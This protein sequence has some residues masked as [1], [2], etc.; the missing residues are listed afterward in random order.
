[1]QRDRLLYPCYFDRALRRSEG[2]RVHRTMAVEHPAL[3]DIEKAAKKL[4]LSCRVEE[5]SHPRHWNAKEGRVAVAWEGPK[6]ELIRRV[7][8]TL[9]RGA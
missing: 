5:A 6:E 2:R 3:K 7:A 8:A 4:G 9:S 1:M